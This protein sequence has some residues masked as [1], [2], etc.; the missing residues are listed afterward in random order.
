MDVDHFESIFIE[1]L[2]PGK[3]III[4]GN[5]YRSHGTNTNMFLADLGNC[6]TKITAEDKQCYISGDFNFDL[7]HFND[8]K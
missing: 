4:V 5:I 3:K 1:I 6:L 2:V 7:L 8:N